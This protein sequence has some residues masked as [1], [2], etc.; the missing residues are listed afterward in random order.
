MDASDYLSEEMQFGVQFHLLMSR[1]DTSAD[2][3]PQL[4]NAINA[5]E[6]STENRERLT[7][8]LGALL[9]RQEYM[10]LFAGSTEILSE[11]TIILSKNELA[12]PDKIIVK[13]KETILLDYKTGVPS[14]KDEKQINSYRRTLESMGYP[15]V[16]SYLFYTATNELRFVG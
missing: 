7:N 16:S 12:R 13:A 15:H 6:V 14:S 2:I 11:Q 5:G 4:S 10:D 1:I 8:K 9:N 3:E